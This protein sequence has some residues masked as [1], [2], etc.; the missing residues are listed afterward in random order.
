MIAHIL[1]A[2]SMFTKDTYEMIS[3]YFNNEKEEHVF[4]S[5]FP[6]YECF[7]NGDCRVVASRSWEMIRTLNKADAIVVHGLI[8]KLVVWI[9]SAQ[10]WLLKKCN[11]IVWGGDIYI[12]NKQTL[13]LSEKFTELLKKAIIPKIPVIST[14]AKGDYEL[15]KKWYGA[16]GVESSIVYPVPAGNKEL[17]EQLRYTKAHK[18]YD[19]VNI[20]VGNS[21]TIT[22][23]HKEALDVLSKFKNEKIKIFLPLS[24]GT[25]EFEPYADS[26]IQYAKSIFG[27]KVVPV[28]HKMAGDEYLEFLSQ[29]DVG[30]FNNNRQQAMGNISQLVLFG[31][32]VYI[33]SDTKMWGH[34]QGLGCCLNDFEEI[35]QMTSIEELSLED[36]TRKEQNIK[37]I[38]SRH[39]IQNKVNQWSNMFSVMKQVIQY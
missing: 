19:E 8:N 22:N 7:S 25:G 16:K 26:V 31:T 32:K 37:I 10:P 33:R 13:T 4:I 6:E 18:T 11:W 34:F 35:K 15:A 1:G 12:H 2:G 14:V 3:Q 28:R 9:L 20:I 24:Y 23:Q 36:S 30:V 27:D 39:D 21:A 5:K 17:V 38:E 29:M